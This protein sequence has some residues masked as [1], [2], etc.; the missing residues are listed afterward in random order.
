MW[1]IPN[2][3]PWN[4]TISAIADHLDP[5]D[6]CRMY[7]KLWLVI[8]TSLLCR[9]MGNAWS[10]MLVIWTCFFR[11]VFLLP[12]CN[13]FFCYDEKRSWQYLTFSK[14]HL[15]AYRYYWIVVISQAYSPWRLICSHFQTWLN[16][17]FLWC[18]SVD[19]ASWNST[20]YYAMD[21]ALIGFY[22]LMNG[23][24]IF[25]PH[26]SLHLPLPLLIF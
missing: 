17:T 4:E 22:L 20:A 2:Y 25:P 21:L 13:P 5:D 15:P 14:Q 19:F 24:L 9:I 3:Q 10:L 8:L 6:H 7:L 1:W 26:T 18:I 11:T 23:T 12:M 16:L